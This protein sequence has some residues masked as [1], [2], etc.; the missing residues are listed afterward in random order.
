MFNENQIYRRK[1][2]HDMYGGNRQSGISPSAKTP[3]IFIFTGASGA[4]HGYKDE[5]LNED[6]FSYT[7]EGQSG[8]MGFT[9]GNLALRD[10]LSTGKRV[11]LFEYIARGMV[12]FV[13]ELTF[14][15]SDYF[16][17][18]DTSGGLRTGIKFFF[19]RV[20]EAKYLIPEELKMTIIAAE[21]NEAYSIFKKPN[22]TERSRLVTS[23][24]G[25][26][27]YRKSILHRW[28]YQ[29]A[30]TGYNDTR[31]LI[32]SHIQSW[33]DSSDS[34]RLDVDNGILLSPDYDALFDKHLISFDV[35]GRIILSSEINT[36]PIKSLG[37]TGNEKINNLT[38]GNRY[39]LKLHNQI[40]K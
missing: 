4:Q 2:I 36:T 10:H 5:W 34:Q 6:V 20:G 13:G 1:D 32:A 11:F 37:I 23:R 3:Y 14:L 39:Y 30:A 29:C 31:I 38:E 9:K 25:Q 19:R 18:H 24:V 35:S 21:P 26:G 33:K 15:D 16:E 7:G 22:S 12:M 27:A 40:I 28:S 17:T 8:D